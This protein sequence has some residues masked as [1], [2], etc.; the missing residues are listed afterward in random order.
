M[1]IALILAVAVLA[2]EVLRA[3]FEQLPVK[4]PLSSRSPPA[5]LADRQAWR[6]AGMNAGDLVRIEPP[7]KRR[8]VLHLRPGRPTLEGP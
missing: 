4:L 8:R 5:R 3:G 2:R 6:D 1:Y 7:N